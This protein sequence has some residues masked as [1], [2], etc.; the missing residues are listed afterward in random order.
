M[1][2]WI[3]D[4]IG[5]IVDVGGSA[6]DF[7]FPGMGTIAQEAFGE[8]FDE[9]VSGGIAETFTA[10]EPVFFEA[11]PAA[12]LPQFV[13]SEAILN[14][15]DEWGAGEFG[16]TD[17]DFSGQNI[18]E[19]EWELMGWPDQGWRNVAGNIIGLLTGSGEAQAM[20]TFPTI[21]RGVGTVMPGVVGAIGGVLGGVAAAGAR[22][23]ASIFGRGAGAAAR[24][25]I[26]GITGSVA[27]LWKYVRSHGAATVAAALGISLGALGTILLQNPEK[28]RWRRRGISSRDI[29]TTK[30]VVGFVNRI[31]H[32]IG[33]VRR[34]S[35]TRKHHHHK[36][37]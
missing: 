16:T 12:L 2:D 6:L 31:S 21:A 37:T 30:R 18:V 33:C 5:T 17:Y 4:I 34:P 1:L 35:F 8:L 28:R 3:G 10:A 13:T 22:T 36:G 29:R 14:G 20:G 27:Q 32:D 24:F 25:S 26:N 9:G 7:G 23:I 11:V 15:V 19:G